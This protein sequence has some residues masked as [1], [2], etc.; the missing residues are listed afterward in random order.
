[1]RRDGGNAVNVVIIILSLLLAVAFIA[2][3]WPKAVA[4]RTAQGQAEHLRVPM[5]G[6]RALGVVEIAAALGLILGLWWRPV[7]LLAS[8]GLV[9]LMVGATIA[10]R[11]VGDAPSAAVPALVLGLVALLDFI[12]IVTR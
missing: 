7:G 12:L 1:M 6:Y 8:G 10:H 9:V 11:R 5:G 4:N 2:T 3:G